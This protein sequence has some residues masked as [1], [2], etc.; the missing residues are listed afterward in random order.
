MFTRATIH[1]VF[2]AVNDTFTLIY[3]SICILD[4]A[5]GMFNSLL[6]ILQ[7]QNIIN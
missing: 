4:R 1:K 6:L 3:V 5:S 2:N 7:A